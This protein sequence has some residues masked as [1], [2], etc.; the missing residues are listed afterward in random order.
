M[1]QA[2]DVGMVTLTAEVAGGAMTTAFGWN[3][4][5]RTGEISQALKRSWDNPAQDQASKQTIAGATGSFIVDGLLMTAGGVAGARRSGPLLSDVQK[6]NEVSVPTINL[7]EQFNFGDRRAFKSDSPEARAYSKLKDSV[8]KVEGISHEQGKSYLNVESGFFVDDSGR[9]MTTLHSVQRART[10]KVRTASGASFN[11][12]VE[13]FDAPND[14][15]L[16][17][18]TNARP[19]NTF[20]PLPL[21]PKPDPAPGSQIFGLGF[22]APNQ[23]ARTLFL[24]P[25]KFINRE[26]LLQPGEISGNTAARWFA[27]EDTNRMVLK[28][29]MNFAGGM[30]GGPLVDDRGSVLGLITSASRQTGDRP[31]V[32]KATLGKELFKLYLK[33][34]PVT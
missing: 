27:G 5:R 15:A 23:Q 24:S 10:I 31:S 33:A 8:V 30:G 4:L 3:V 29:E 6:T 20:K 1:M 2:G 18:L 21:V 28:S 25:G 14:L 32:S 19:Y 9:V 34:V 7:D 16:L 12:E 17:K 13:H 22:P 26:S 11:A